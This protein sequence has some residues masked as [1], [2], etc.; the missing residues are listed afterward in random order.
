MI[1]LF[2]LSECVMVVQGSAG[3]SQLRPVDI[4]LHLWGM[5]PLKAWSSIPVPTRKGAHPWAAQQACHG[6]MTSRKS[7]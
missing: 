6:H 7:N 3:N 5:P 1:M 4:K 2:V